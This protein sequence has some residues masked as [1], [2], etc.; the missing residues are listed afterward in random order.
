[1][2]MPTTVLKVSL[3]DINPQFFED[4][5]GDLGKDAEVEI[6]VQESRHGEGLFSEAD[7]WQVVD[8]LDWSNRNRAAISAPAAKAL[9][10]MH[11]SS[12]YLFQDILSEKLYRLDTR[13]HAQA[14][15]EKQT[16]GSFSADDFL[17]VRCA[18]VAEG[19]DYYEKVLKNPS[20]MPGNIDF[21]HLL[22]L[23]AEAYRL[24]TGRAFDY[25]PLFN[26]ETHS[27]ANGWE[28]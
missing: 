8:L 11:I 9:S 17:Y 14:Y 19:K 21:E 22:T 16:D 2:N 12:I 1:M 7:F 13:Q 20:E 27:N 15:R 24:K 5:K 26:Y 3:E 25:V 28:K 6:R 10:R 4:L 18:V 23:A